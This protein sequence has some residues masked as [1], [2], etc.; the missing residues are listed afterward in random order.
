MAS[1]NKI[2]IGIDFDNTIVNYDNLFS[3]ALSE[4]SWKDCVS[5]GNTKSSIKT[6]LFRC[7]GNDLRWQELQAILYGVLIK[8]APPFPGVLDALAYLVS[9]GGFEI[10]IVSHKSKNSLY[11][12]SITFVDKAFLWIQENKISALIPFE[13]I[14]FAPT[15]D[16]KIEII[17]NLNL[18]FFI[19]DLIEVLIDKNFPNIN[20]ILFSVE[21]TNFQNNEIITLGNWQSIKKNLMAVR[22]L[23]NKEKNE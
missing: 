20:K 13:N 7:D 2:R 10:F 16:E 12:P 23:R 21:A 5:L 17:R 18:D 3:R 22:K 9:S 8:D 6:N 1:M 11:L 14:F 4:T 15:R 19:D